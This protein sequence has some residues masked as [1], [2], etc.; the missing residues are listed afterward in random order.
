MLPGLST[1]PWKCGVVRCGATGVR[2]GKVLCGQNPWDCS[3]WRGVVQHIPEK[4]NS[5]GFKP[6]LPEPTRNG[7]CNDPKCLS[8]DLFFLM[9]LRIY[10]LLPQQ[11][12]RYY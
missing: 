1:D 3:V 6:R 10:T 9:R 11:P 7:I 8:A 2:R 4:G 5:Q 12:P